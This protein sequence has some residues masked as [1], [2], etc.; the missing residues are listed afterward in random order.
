MNYVKLLLVAII[1]S[2]PTITQESQ[3]H[4]F[5][6][7]SDQFHYAEIRMY[8][9]ECALSTDF[10]HFIRANNGERCNLAGRST[11]CQ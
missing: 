5:D 1:L 8:H 11:A 6:S 7:L 4:T 10:T 9:G 3:H 2:I